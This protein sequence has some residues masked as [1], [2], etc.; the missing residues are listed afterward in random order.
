M[1]VTRIEQSSFKESLG[2]SLTFP[3]SKLMGHK[4]SYIKDLTHSTSTLQKVIIAAIIL[5]TFPVSL[6]LMGMGWL[7]LRSCQKLPEKREVREEKTV[8]KPALQSTN[9]KNSK[10]EASLKDSQGRQKPISSST[11][12]LIEKANPEEK[13]EPVEEPKPV[14]KP[15][16][17]VP[18][19]FFSQKAPTVKVKEEPK[20]VVAPAQIVPAINVEDIKTIKEKAFIEIDKVLEECQKF[21]DLEE[22]IPADEQTGYFENPQSDIHGVKFDYNKSILKEDFAFF[23]SQEKPKADQ[24]KSVKEIENWQKHVVEHLTKMKEALPYHLRLKEDAVSPFPLVGIPNY[25]GNNCFLNVAL[26]ALVHTRWMDYAL[27]RP[28]RPIQDAQK[29]Q[30]L[31]RLNQLKTYEE[32]NQEFSF[33]EQMQLARYENNLPIYAEALAFQAAFRQAIEKMR[34]GKQLDKTDV[35]RLLKVLKH[36]EGRPGAAECI[37]YK[38]DLLTADSRRIGAETCGREAL[39]NKKILYNKPWTVILAGS[40][41]HYWCFVKGAQGIKKA[42]DGT[43]SNRVSS[44][45]E[46]SDVKLN[47]HFL[48]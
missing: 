33:E 13:R 12:A 27:L 48:S 46:V 45:E 2:H 28:L 38:F 5:A 15:V 37:F 36:T 30:K 31:A 39:E 41:V 4:I 14:V 1:N 17:I 34:K 25:H 20:P 26:Q 18:S 44:L 29:D 40:G 35:S 11:T 21:I 22:R 32:K 19:Q 7:L 24:L 16:K 9:P 6:P 3:I 47:I 23:I 10:K 42:N 43:I 8:Q